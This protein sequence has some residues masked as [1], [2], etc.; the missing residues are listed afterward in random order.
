MKVSS[1]SFTSMILYRGSTFSNFFMRE[2]SVACSA[3]S[4]APSDTPLCQLAALDCFRPTAGI[5]IGFPVS[6]PLR[7]CDRY[8]AACLSSKADLGNSALTAAIISALVATLFAAIV[9]M[10]TCLMVRFGSASDFLVFR[11]RCSGD[12]LF[13]VLGLLC[14][15][16]FFL[17]LHFGSPESISE[18]LD[19]RSRT[20]AD[21]VGFDRECPQENSLV[22]KMSSGF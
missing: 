16:L 14:R 2:F 21:R 10:T 20:G 18:G 12:R 1:A 5:A 4:E 13:A 11:G 3:S 22:V 6:N 8:H 7:A 9:S 19:C 15:L 17:A